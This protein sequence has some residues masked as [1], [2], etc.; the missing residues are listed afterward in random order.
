MSKFDKKT[1]KAF[2]KLIKK[3]SKFNNIEGP[4]TID[5]HGIIRIGSL[6]AP[7]QLIRDLLAYNEEKNKTSVP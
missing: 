2:H 4:M 1:F 3:H 6:I 5:K 7:I